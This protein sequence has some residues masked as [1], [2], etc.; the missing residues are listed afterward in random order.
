MSSNV[1]SNWK[2]RELRPKGEG[3]VSST[4]I[5]FSVEGKIPPRNRV[6]DDSTEFNWWEDPGFETLRKLEN[7]VSHELQSVEL[8]EMKDKLTNVTVEKPRIQEIPNRDH[9]TIFSA[10]EASD[11]IPDGVELDNESDPTENYYT[12]TEKLFGSS[13]ND[14]D[15]LKESFS[16]QK[17][18]QWTVIEGSDLESKILYVGSNEKSDGRYD[19]ESEASN[20]PTQSI[21]INQKDPDR[22]ILDVP[23]TKPNTT[24]E[25]LQSSLDETCERCAAICSI[26]EEQKEINV[27]LMA[28]VSDLGIGN[29][30]E[31]RNRLMNYINELNTNHEGERKRAEQERTELL[32]ALKNS[33]D[34]HR[35][36]E[37]KINQ[38]THEKT[39]SIERTNSVLSECGDLRRERQE[40]NDRSAAL[41]E[42]QTLETSRL[43]KELSTLLTLKEVRD[44]SCVTVP[45]KLIMKVDGP[46]I[47]VAETHAQYSDFTNDFSCQTSEDPTFEYMY[48]TLN[49]SSKSTSAYELDPKSQLVKEKLERDYAEREEKIIYLKNTN[50]QQRVEIQNLEKSSKIKTQ[51]MDKLKLLYRRINH[52]T[53]EEI[54]K[55]MNSIF[56]FAPNE[57]RSNPVVSEKTASL[58]TEKTRGLVDRIHNC[59]QKL[60][61]ESLESEPHE[62]ARLLEIVKR[63]NKKH[64]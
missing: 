51:M 14:K 55:N 18:H 37:N 25:F 59:L 34:D 49:K 28:K 54:G 12:Q 58:V 47:A 53:P 6:G 40:E 20:Q 7:K 56:N 4:K 60:G 23:Y 42:A 15:S 50:A 21:N 22:A 1:K 32:S 9:Q 19:F 46:T 16:S 61:T 31:E 36:L 64:S 41:I 11:D 29:W 24:K 5:D 52:M 27:Q 2:R 35:A 62:A 17:D 43:E 13:P 44:T 8:R 26:L 48:R 57:I 39:L 10:Y 45:S 38:L 3:F 30:T 63:R 33:V